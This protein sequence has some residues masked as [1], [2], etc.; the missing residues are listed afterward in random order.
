VLHCPPITEGGKET[1]LSPSDRCYEN[2]DVHAREGR[3]D[4]VL[5]VN[6]VVD[7]QGRRPSYSCNINGF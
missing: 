7:V 3:N 4:V 2:A 6:R 1:G 5:G